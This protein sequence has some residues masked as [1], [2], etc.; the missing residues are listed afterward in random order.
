MTIRTALFTQK[1]MK[2]LQTAVAV[3]CF[4][5]MIFPLYWLFSSSLKT[6]AS[7]FAR[8]PEIFPLRPTLEAYIT[9]LNQVTFDILGSF[10]NS[11]L[12][13]FCTMVISVC[14][15]VPAA[16][17]LARFR[18]KGKNLIVFLFLV[19]QMLPQIFTLIPNFIIFKKIGIYNTYWAPILSNCTL[20]FLSH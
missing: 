8:P 20:A 18:L 2:Q 9:Q 12:I 15:A 4:L 7:V 17:G 13:S 11:L 3:I 16:Y 14:L 19:S 1:R 10:K 5:F 6:E